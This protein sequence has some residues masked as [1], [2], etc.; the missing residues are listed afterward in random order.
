MTA[1]GLVLAAGLVA[2]ALA[3]LTDLITGARHDRLRAV[4]YL[5]GGA[6]AACL[7]AAGAGS[8][9]GQPVRLAVAGW[10]G[11]GTAWPPTDCPECS[12]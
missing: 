1:F 6:G 2:F 8:L 9:A 10:L 11:A 5:V 12:C 4:P 7:A 3:G